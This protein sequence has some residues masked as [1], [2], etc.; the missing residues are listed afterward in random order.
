MDEK[1]IVDLSIIIP[2][3]NSASTIERTIES[4]LSQTMVPKEIIV[5]NDGSVD[6]SEKIVRNINDSRIIL[7]RQDNCGTSAAKNN[8]IM[9]S[10]G[11]YIMFID[12]DDIIEK[13][14][15]ENHFK[16][17]DG[18][19]I[20]CSGMKV[21]YPLRELEININSND[22]DTDKV[23][24]IKTLLYLL[25]DGELL[26]V[27]VAKVFKRRSLLDNKILFDERLRAGEDLKFNCEYFRH[28]KNGMLLSYSGYHYIR[29]ENGS[30]VSSYKPEID[31]IVD[32]EIQTRK[33]LYDYYSLLDDEFF[34]KRYYYTTMNA[35]ITQIPNYYRDNCPLN[36]EDKVSAIQKIKES[37]SSIPVTRHANKQDYVMFWVLNKF[38]ARFANGIFSCLFYLK[39]RFHFIYRKL[40]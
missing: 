30:L 37:I 3:Y 28:I 8:G 39:K 9:H 21:E 15:I 4:I 25:E 12:S 18:C 33:R 24:D 38:S 10:T 23:V 6:D 29:L 20:V 35:Y 19:D 26:N 17:V 31:L 36:K 1:N 5:V 16:W 2:M 32:E 14:Y 40:F 7:L 13:N 27:D 22:S 34:C 11:E